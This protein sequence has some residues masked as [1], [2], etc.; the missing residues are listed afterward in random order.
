MLQQSHGAVKCVLATYRNLGWVKLSVVGASRGQVNPAAFD[1]LYYDLVWHFKA[2]NQVKL[3]RR[4]TEQH[5][6]R[7]VSVLLNKP[8]WNSGSKLNSIHSINIKHFYQHYI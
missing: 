6:G 3:G 4:V 8:N 7:R 2:Q 5:K 1:T